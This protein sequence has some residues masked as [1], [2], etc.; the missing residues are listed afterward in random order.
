MILVMKRSRTPQRPSHTVNQPEKATRRVTAAEG[1]LTR[2]PRRMA[3][4]KKQEK[5]KAFNHRN[6]RGYL[7]SN[8][9]RVGKPEVRAEGYLR[10]CLLRA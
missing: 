8:V 6:R 1:Q 4:R 5:R 7:K 3:K 2:R 10:P 9:R